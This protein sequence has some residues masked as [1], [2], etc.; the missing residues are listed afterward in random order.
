MTRS[1]FLGRL[2]DVRARNETQAEARCPAHEDGRRS[3]SVGAGEDGRILL[4]CHAG[5][6]PAAIV[7]A[8]GLSLRDLMPERPTMPSGNGRGRIIATYDYRD[9]TGAL[10]SQAIRFE[11]KGFSQRHRA[12]PGCHPDKNPDREGWCWTIKGL[13]RVVY[14]LPKVRAAIEAGRDIFVV[15]GEKDSDNLGELGLVATCNAMGAGKWEQAHTDCLRGAANVYVIPDKDAPGRKHAAAVAASLHAAGI[16]VAIVELPGAGKDASDWIATGGTRAELERL[17]AAAAEWTPSAAD[18]PPGATDLAHDAPAAVVGEG[19]TESTLAER[20][21]ASYGSDLLFCGPWRKWLI[22]RGG[23]WEECPTP[24][25]V[26]QRTIRLI[27]EARAQAA[28]GSGAEAQAAVK[29]LFAA[30]KRSV[31]DSIVALAAHEAAVQA[32]PG[33][34]DRD[35][36]LLN[37]LNGTVDL[38]TGERREHQRADRLTKMAPVAYDRAAA[39]P[40]WQA[41]LERIFAGNPE[42]LAFIQRAIGYSLTA[43]TGEQCLFICWGA[44]ANGKSTLLEALRFVLGDYARAAPLDLFVASKGDRHPTELATL[45]GVRFAPCVETREGARL[46]ETLLKQ[47]TGSDTVQAR[48][49]R[50]DFWEFQ[51]VAKLWLGTNHRPTI[52]GTDTAIWRRVRLI[53]FTVTIPPE[54]RDRELPAKLRAEAPGILRWAVEG[55]LAWQR[56]GLCPPADVTCATDAYRQD[57]DR[58]GAF[59]AECCKTGPGFVAKSADLF[60]AYARWA[61]DRRE[62]VGTAKA[63]AL[64]L[65]ERGFAAGTSG[66]AKTSIRKGIGLLEGVRVDAGRL[67]VF[68]HVARASR[69]QPD[70]RPA[71]TRNG[72]DDDGQGDFEEVRP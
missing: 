6:E 51:P 50:E 13:P 39:A 43:D 16:F 55:C 63:F 68:P 54:E 12:S 15:E 5:C 18:L 59:I 34:F 22:Y 30:E 14:R 66:H 21:I 37:V 70:D 7:S 71:S 69:N 64:A 9:E 32:A 26:Q 41:F 72:L 4:H 36:L 1:D 3:L 33:E 57:E 11:P 2:A 58:L 53:P 48:R 49:M 38:R 35:P 67:E 61:E 40:A 65:E 47:L 45:A 29:A 24:A 52:R 62:F 42:M 17:A 23:R 20:L 8:L 19:V 28:R 56:E 25:P 44:G 31:R 46:N 60:A 10:I 27:R